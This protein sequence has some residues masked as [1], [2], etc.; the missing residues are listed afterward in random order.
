MQVLMNVDVEFLLERFL[1][2]S[3]DGDVIHHELAAE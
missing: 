1:K 2:N 3:G